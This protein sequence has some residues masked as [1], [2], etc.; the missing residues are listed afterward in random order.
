MSIATINA[1]ITTAFST[2]ERGKA[3]GLIGAVVSVGL[4]TGPAVA[5]FLIDTLGW[6]SI[7]YLRLPISILAMISAFFLLKADHPEKRQGRFDFIGAGLLLLAIPSLLFVL[8]RGQHLGWDSLLIIGLSIIGMVSLV[9]FIITER[10]VEQPILDLRLFYSRFFSTVT[11]SHILLYMSTASI[12][13]TMPFF[14][15]KS[16]SMPTTEA[17]LLLVTIPGIRMV[18]S[19][20]SGKLSDKLGTRLLCGV[21]FCMIIVGMLL[22]RRLTIGASIAEIMA[23]FV[24]IGLGMGLFTIPNTSAIMGAVPNERLGTAAAMVGLLRQL[25]MSIGLAIAGSFFATSSLS[26]STELLSQG[27]A[28]ELVEK[29]SIAEGMQDTLLL[30]LLF[31]VLG[32]V[33]SILRGREK[34]TSAI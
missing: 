20:L 24:I 27:I 33:I 2:E 4:L 30:A 11:G 21:G 22:L 7:F 6:R 17:G 16:L 34:R 25:G 12:D 14:L 10:K 5:G 9:L 23:L 31:P 26:H 29:L 13:F 28:A 19:P 8:N 3:L 1:I 15:I 18:V 32:L